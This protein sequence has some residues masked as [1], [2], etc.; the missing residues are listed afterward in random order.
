MSFLGDMITNV[1]V[2]RFLNLNP[3]HC[4]DPARII[5]GGHLPPF[6]VPQG[7]ERLE[8]SFGGFKSF[9]LKKQGGKAKNCVYLIHGG[10]FIAGLSSMYYQ[11]GMTL[12]DALGCDVY[13]IDYR[14]APEH[15]Y[16]C[17]LEDTRTGWAHLQ[18]LGYLPENTAL[19]GDSAGGNLV[20]ALLLSLRDAGRPMPACGVCFSAWA[21]MTANGASYIANYG[22][23]PMFGDPT[24]VYSD[25]LKERLL[26]SEI[27][28]YAEGADRKDPYLSPVYGDYHGFVPMYFVN[29]ADEILLSD[30]QTICEKLRA[31]GTEAVH[32]IC[33]GLFH[34]FPIFPFLPEAKEYMRR[35]CAFIGG[36]FQTEPDR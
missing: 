25:E 4:K 24:A 21:D 32:D 9:L 30:A 33:P 14:L 31:C 28:S 34:A 35:A 10:A 20:L 26:H 8:Y 15:V 29:S 7:Y 1:A 36:H 27:Y 11:M 2:K 22:K 13:Y 18:S 17:A 16:P 23:D 6:Q 5:G 19:L 12:I 3:S